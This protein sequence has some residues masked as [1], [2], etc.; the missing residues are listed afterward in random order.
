MK[1]NDFKMPLSY[2]IREFFFPNFS[3]QSRIKDKISELLWP[4]Q[5][6]LTKKIPSHW[7]DKVELIPIC[8]Y[9]MIVHFVEHEMDNVSW[10]WQHEVDDGF[11]SQEQADRVKQT[12]ETIL[13]I[14]NWIKKGKPEMQAEA[15]RCLDLAYKNFSFENLSFD[16]TP[17]EEEAC[18]NYRKLEDLIDKTDQ[19]ML[20]KIIE[21]RQYLWT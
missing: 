9:E 2:R 19:K 21:V 4:R 15:D 14:Y 7:C 20:H 3:I 6:W 18:E 17:E 10:D 5:Q 11:I 12:K 13:E 8:L 1:I 16:L